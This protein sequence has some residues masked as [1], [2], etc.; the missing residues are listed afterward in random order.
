MDRREYNLQVEYLL[1]EALQV[2][3]DKG[4][5]YTVGS[6]DVLKNFKSVAERTGLDPKQVLGIY[7]MKHQDAIANYIKS[8]GQSE[9][10]PIKY[11]IIDN[12][13]YLLLLWGL[14]QDEAPQEEKSYED[15]FSQSE[16]SKITGQ[17]VGTANE[18][19]SFST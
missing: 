15:K 13:N 2:S 17:N 4:E 7:M 1:D 6:K 3:R 16:G 19:V 9:S 12:I 8:N 11:R 10:E 5:D 18:S 14:I